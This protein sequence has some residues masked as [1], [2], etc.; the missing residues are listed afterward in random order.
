MNIIILTAVLVVSY[1]IGSVNSSIVVGYIVNRD[2]IRKYGS[3]NAGATNVLRTYGRV[4]AL[5]V[6]LGD[7]LKGVLA[8]LLAWWMQSYIPCNEDVV[9]PIEYFILP[10][11]AALGAFWGHIFPLYFKFKG[12]KGVATAVALG[13]MLDVRVALLI[14]AVALPLLFITHY[15]SLAAVLGAASYPCVTFF[16]NY[17]D[18]NR[19]LAALYAA[20]IGIMI[21]ITHRSNIKRLLHGCENKISFKRKE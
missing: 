19:I 13:L 17:S 16:W 20:I 11:I 4:A 1:L 14:L 9:V 3:G 2:D 18:D 21:I 7:M 10:Y 6:L 12:G 15:V 8:V 5:C